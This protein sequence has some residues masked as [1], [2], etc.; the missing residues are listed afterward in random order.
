MDISTHLQ[1][2]DP[3]RAP[4]DVPLERDLP[5]SG[6]WPGHSSLAP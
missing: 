5:V 6:L 3:Q 4:I 1:D 2:L